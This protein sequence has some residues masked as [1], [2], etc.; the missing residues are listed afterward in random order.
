MNKYIF[1]VLMLA[2][3]LWFGISALLVFIASLAFGFK[4]SIFQ[5][6]FV[7]VVGIVIRGCMP[8]KE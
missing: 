3:L 7:F 5:I 4:M 2:F 1:C 6:L 8:S